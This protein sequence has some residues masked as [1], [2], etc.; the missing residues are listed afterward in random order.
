MGLYSR[1]YEDLIER[2]ER[3]LSGK[4]NCITW[5][6][7]RFEVELPGIEQ[8]KYYLFTANSKVGRLLPL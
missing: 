1:V 7:P 3:V 4:I 2:R 5:S 8:G 6:L